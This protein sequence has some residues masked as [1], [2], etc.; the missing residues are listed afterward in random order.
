[1]GGFTDALDR[2]VGASVGAKGFVSLLQAAAT[3]LARV[4]FRR[5]VCGRPCRLATCVGRHNG[6]AG[7]VI[8]WRP[9]AHA[10]CA[11]FARALGLS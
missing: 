4:F 7:V 2:C 11:P 8:E 6:P 9:R 3:C 5:V 1:M 10:H